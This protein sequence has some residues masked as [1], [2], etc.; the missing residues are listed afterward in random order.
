MVDGG[1]WSL[2]RYLG[3]SEVVELGKDIADFDDARFV[4]EIV[5][6]VGVDLETVFPAAWRALGEPGE[7][8]VLAEIRAAAEAIA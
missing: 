2:E 3:R 8:M 7:A 4:D 5:L 1:R 6:D